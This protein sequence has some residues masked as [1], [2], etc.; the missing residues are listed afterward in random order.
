[1]EPSCT[2]YVHVSVC[3][4]KFICTVWLIKSEQMNGFLSS[5]YL[6]ICLDLLN[7]IGLLSGG[8]TKLMLVKS[9]ISST[10]LKETLM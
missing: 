2:P 5:R 10:K 3:H 9:G 4:Q 6:K 8:T 1:M 7:M